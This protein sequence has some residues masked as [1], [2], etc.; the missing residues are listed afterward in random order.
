MACTRR[1]EA[2]TEGITRVLRR[3]ET[4]LLLLLGLGLLITGV[5][6]DESELVVGVGPGLMSLAVLLSLVR[7]FKVGVF[8]ATFREQEREVGYADFVATQSDSLRR[9]AV[10]LGAGRGA[11]AV[12]AD[13]LA[14]VSVHWDGDLPACRTH[15]ICQIVHDVLGGEREGARYRQALQALLDRGFDAATI[16]VF[17]GLPVDRVTDDL[18]RT[19]VTP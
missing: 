17:V 3:P 14:A 1:S 11:K 13:A 19:G 12:V 5:V 15:A 2:W 8:S 7:E 18:V 16:A 6:L 9:L 10:D 4:A